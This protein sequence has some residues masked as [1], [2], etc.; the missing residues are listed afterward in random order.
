MLHQPA[1]GGMASLVERDVL[2]LL[3]GDDLVLLLQ[4][5]DHAVHGIQEILAVDG[6][7]LLPGRDEGG[8]VADVGDVGPGETRRLLGEE[9][10]VHGG[11]QF[12]GLQ[13]HLEDGHALLEVGHVHVDLTVEAS[14][15]Q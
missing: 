13:V 14:G 12:Q 1:H 9:L 5:T 6:L 2:L 10:H 7:L 8:L 15:A 4:T 11:V 3:A